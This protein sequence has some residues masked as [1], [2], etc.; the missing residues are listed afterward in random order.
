MGSFQPFS[1]CGFKDTRANPCRNKCKT[2]IKCSFVFG[3]S[4]LFGVYYPATLF[5]TIFLEFPY[6][7][8]GNKNLKHKH[9][10][11]DLNIQ[12]IY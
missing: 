3:C 6:E 5:R 10:I 7:T 11:N 9:K 2:D 8:I 12:R 1:F 4:S